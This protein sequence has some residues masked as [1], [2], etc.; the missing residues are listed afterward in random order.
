MSTTGNN[1]SSKGEGGMDSNHSS[2]NSFESALDST[3]QPTESASRPPRLAESPRVNSFESALDSIL[4]PTKSASQHESQTSRLAESPR[5]NSFESAINSS[6]QPTQSAIR[7]PRLAE[8]SRVNSFESALDSPL[9]PTESAS[10]H[11]S[12]T[13]RLS[14]SLR[15]I[16]EQFGGFMK[17]IRGVQNGESLPYNYQRALEESINMEIKE[18]E[19][20]YNEMRATLN[21]V[22][23]LRSQRKAIRKEMN[24]VEKLIRKIEYE[25]TQELEKAVIAHDKDMFSKWES[26]K[27]STDLTAIENLLEEAEGKHQAMTNLQQLLTRKLNDLTLLPPPSTPPSTTTVTQPGPNRL[28]DSRIAKPRLMRKLDAR[29]S[30]LRLTRLRGG[31]TDDVITIRD[32]LEAV[33]QSETSADIRMALNT[34]FG[35]RATNSTN[36]ASGTNSTNKTNT[37]D[38]QS[39][40]IHLVLTPILNDFSTGNERK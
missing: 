22:E 39:S 12:Q 7:T 38:L 25:E 24:S 21:N 29:K 33:D 16:Y 2:V 18:L 40:D 37:P 9:Q 5:V 10:Q 17:W 31:N 27:T 6:L 32:S 11:E 14:E 23:C 4:Q 1:L 30:R 26:V 19:F 15:V 3:L 35:A 20:L 36:N 8:S 34:L 13:R 28:A